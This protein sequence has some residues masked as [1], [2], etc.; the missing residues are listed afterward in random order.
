[1]DVVQFKNLNDTNP[2]K[3]RLVP[4]A[5]AVSDINYPGAITMDGGAILMKLAKLFTGCISNRLGIFNNT[6]SVPPATDVY[7]GVA[8]NSGPVEV[9]RLSIVDQM[10]PMGSMVDVLLLFTL[11]YNG[12]FNPSVSPFKFDNI[13]MNTGQPIGVPPGLTGVSAEE[14]HGLLSNTV[15]FHDVPGEPGINL[16]PYLT[17]QPIPVTLHSCGVIINGNS[18]SLF[19]LLRFTPNG[20]YL[21][22][23]PYPGGVVRLDPVTATGLQTKGYIEEILKPGLEEPLTHLSRDG[24]LLTLRSKSYSGQI[25]VEEWVPFR[26]FT[27]NGGLFETEVLVDHNGERPGPGY[28]LAFNS[29]GSLLV[30]NAN[31]PFDTGTNT[32]FVYTKQVDGSYLQTSKYDLP[33]GGGGYSCTFSEDDSYVIFHDVTGTLFVYDIDAN[34]VL[35]ITPYAWEGVFNAYTPYPKFINVAPNEYLHLDR[36]TLSHLTIDTVGK[37]ITSVV[38]LDNPYGGDRTLLTM[39]KIDSNRILI[40]ATTDWSTG[41]PIIVSYDNTTKTA[42]LPSKDITDANPPFGNSSGLRPYAIHPLDPTLVVVHSD[43]PWQFTKWYRINLD[44]SLTEEFPNVI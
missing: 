21:L 40:E 11:Y 41:R 42:T 2:K 28:D 6:I 17:D 22:G 29:T 4:K 19:D 1:M 3:I 10:G 26:L 18:G 9:L 23:I 14:S 13:N 33:G 5:G 16:Y 36:Q 32:F 44:G 20:D 15:V 31:T 30:V 8:Y 39:D 43:T 27:R 12:K 38:V 37:T 35:N 7:I 25:P 24:T 34:G